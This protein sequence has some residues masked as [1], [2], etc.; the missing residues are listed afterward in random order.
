LPESNT[1]APLQTFVN[2][3]GKSLITLG[4]GEFRAD[5]VDPEVDAGLVGRVPLEVERVEGPGIAAHVHNPEAS[6]SSISEKNYACNLH[7]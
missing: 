4:P 1:L 5:A 3:D 6:L 7:Q 2:H